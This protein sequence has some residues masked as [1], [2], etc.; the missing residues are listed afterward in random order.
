VQLCPGCAANASRTIDN[1]R[2]P[3]SD[4]AGCSNCGT[5]YLDPQPTDAQLTEIYSEAY[6]EPWSH[7]APDVVRRMK[8][9]T[10]QPIL[11]AAEA[12]PGQSILDL[13][14]A[15]GELLAAAHAQGLKTFGLDL[16]PSAVAR[17]QDRLATTVFHVGTLAD[18]PFEGDSFDIISMVDFIEHVRDPQA[19]L[20]AAAGRLTGTGR[21]VISTPRRD[22]IVRKLT[23]RHWPQYRHEHLTYLTLSGITQLATRSGLR[24]SFSQRTTKSVTPA[25]L[26]GQALAYPIPVVSP[27]VKRFWR[28]VPGKHRLIR[29][30]FGE[31]TVVLRRH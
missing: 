22:S 11:A 15:T 19:E 10:F 4:L 30:P 14:C 31:M 23:G 1:D 26:F 16:N 8:T 6:Y 5:E 3:G 27:V 24:V 2:F 28:L 7:E 20:E 25:Y 13:G 12:Q 29:L 21:I 9:A 18:E 17:A